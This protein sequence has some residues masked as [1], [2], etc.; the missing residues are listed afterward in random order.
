MW[1]TI[2][3]LK[4][5][6]SH[7]HGLFYISHPCYL[8]LRL[9]KNGFPPSE[10]RLSS[11]MFFSHLLL[12]TSISRYLGLGQ[13]KNWLDTKPCF[14]YWWSNWFSISFNLFSVLDLPIKPFSSQFASKYHFISV[15]RF[16]FWETLYHVGCQT[17]R[18]SRENDLN[19]GN[20]S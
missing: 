8:E 17:V 4:F 13:E 7:I 11:L 12:A 16:S 3:I 15:P 18:Q 10:A 20:S 1:D 5:G 6:C 14:R 9:S 19:M 2:L